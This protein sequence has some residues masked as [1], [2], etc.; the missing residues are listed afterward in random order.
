MKKLFMIAFA[1]V[2]S[3]GIAF[4]QDN[5]SDIDQVGDDSDATVVQDGSMNE[6]VISQ[7]SGF[8]T[9]HTAEVTQ[10]GMENS[11]DIL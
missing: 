8:G 5:D 3:T 6:S 2:F 4:A 7:N 9:G 11:S 10:T 1:L